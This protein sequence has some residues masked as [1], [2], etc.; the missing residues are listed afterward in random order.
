MKHVT[1]SDKSMLVGDEAADLLIGYA[2]LL[3]ARGGSDVVT[4]HAI[5]LD[6]NDVNASFLLNAS[7]ILMVESASTVASE[8]ENGLV[9]DYLRGRIAQLSGEFEFPPNG[10]GE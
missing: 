10:G 2:S 1:Y 9:T 5:G 6:G 4:V 3:G 8:P 7:T